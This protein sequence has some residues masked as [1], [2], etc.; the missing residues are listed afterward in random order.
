VTK[1]MAAVQQAKTDRVFLCGGVAANSGLRKGLAD[2]CAKEE[3]IL[4]VPPLELCTDNAA[5]IAACG[6]EMLRRGQMTSLD[7]SPDPSLALT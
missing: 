2:A 6:A 1:T 7:A 3:T 4:H 5:M